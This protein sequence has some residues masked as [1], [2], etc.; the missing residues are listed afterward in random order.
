MRT[1]TSNAAQ[2]AYWVAVAMM[3]L[4]LAGASYWYLERTLWV[5]PSFIVF[6][7]MYEQHPIISEH[8]YGAFI[9]Q[10]WPLLAHQLNLPLR[11]I[12]WVYSVSFYAFYTAVLLLVG[13]RWKQYALGVLLLLYLTVL[14]SDSYFWPNNE[15]H[16]GIGWMVLALGW[17]NHLMEGGEVSWWKHILAGILMILSLLTHVLVAAPFAFLWVYQIVREGRGLTRTVLTYSALLLA[18]VGLRYYL[19]QDSWYDGY[20]LEGVQNLTVPSFFA[21]FGNGHARQATALLWPDYVGALVLLLTGLC[22][23]LWRGGYLRAIITVGACLLYAGLVLVTYPAPFGRELLF[24]YESEWQGLAIIAATPF[25][26]DL[27]LRWR[28]AY[29]GAAL[30]VLICLVRLDHIRQSAAYFDLR[31]ENLRVLTE[32]LPQRGYHKVLWEGSAELTPY[33]G[34][35]W[36]L[37]G[38]TLLSSSLDSKHATLTLKA[39]DGSEPDG[40]NPGNVFRGD[41]RDV[42]VSRIDSAYFRLDSL[43]PYRRLEAPDRAAIFTRLRTLPQ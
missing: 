1:A 11:I 43:Q 42:P 36:G 27:L 14:V 9:T 35:T 39:I 16:Q 2:A 32:E 21:A 34:L 19:S 18:G 7:V 26:L 29:W 4:L 40:E 38:E 22:Y 17:Y 20:K 24:Y 31:L 6:E 10:M 5:D 23:L 37:P 3:L 15:V 25:C 33:F 30:L 28:R 8:R 12:L 13:W 41:F